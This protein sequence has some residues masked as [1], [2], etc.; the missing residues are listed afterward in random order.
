MN[1]ENIKVE[2]KMCW[3]LQISHIQIDIDFSMA[4]LG[5]W[6]GGQ[7]DGINNEYM[8]DFNYHQHQYHCNRN[9]H[10]M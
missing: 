3:V 4:A 8:F 2:R 6:A 7:Q 1:F 10:L 9:E 5:I